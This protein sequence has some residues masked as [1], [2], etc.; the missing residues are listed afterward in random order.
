MD[1]FSRRKGKEVEAILELPVV[2]G[3]QACDFRLQAIGTRL[4]SR[5]LE[6]TSLWYHITLGGDSLHVNG[7]KK[8]LRSKLL[9]QR[10]EFL[11]ACTKA[12]SWQGFAKDRASVHLRVLMNDVCNFSEVRVF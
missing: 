12:R 6:M 7:D 2:F 10:L 3:K 11:S 5:V 4:E 9:V 8:H 1:V